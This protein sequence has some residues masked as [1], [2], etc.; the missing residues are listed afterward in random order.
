MYPAFYLFK[1]YVQTCKTV[2]SDSI[3]FSAQTGPRG[4]FEIK[5]Y[6]NFPCGTRSLN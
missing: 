1:F 2:K 5:I 4:N 3:S 6:E